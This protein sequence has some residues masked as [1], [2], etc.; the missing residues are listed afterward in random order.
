VFKTPDSLFFNVQHPDSSNAVIN[1]GSVGVVQNPDLDKV[2]E[3]PMG[4]EKETV[5]VAG[6]TYQ[7]LLSEGIHGIGRIED[8]NGVF[9]TYSTDPD[10]NG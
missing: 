3:L 9:M 4:L 1:R 5:T 6:G 10:F 2:L 8:V 7:V